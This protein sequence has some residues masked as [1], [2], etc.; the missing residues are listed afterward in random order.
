MK[1][2]FGILASLLAGCMFLLVSCEKERELPEDN[3]SP[4]FPTEVVTRNVAAG[5]A[6]ELPIEPNVKWTV[7]LSGEGSGN[8]FWIDDDGIKATQLSGNPGQHTIVVKF[9]EDKDFE[10]VVCDVNLKMGDQTRKI[11]TYTRLPQDRSCNVFTGVAGEFDFDKV[12]DSYVYGTS[13]V[14]ETALVTFPE[15]GEYRMPVKV[16]TNFDWKIALP[17]WLSAETVAQDGED[18]SKISEGES[19]TTEIML[20]VVLSDE[21]SNGAEAS[22]KIFDASTLEEQ[23]EMTVTMP[24]FNDRIE[25]VTINSLQFN[26]EACV[27]MPAGSFSEEPM[28]AIAYMF[29][30]EGAAMKAFAVSEGKCTGE[31]ADWVVITQAFDP[32]GGL[33]QSYPLEVSVSVNEGTA[34]Y[35]DLWAFPEALAEM[36]AKEL[37][38]SE[39]GSL[40]KEEY[41]MYYVGRIMQEGVIPPYIKPLSTEEQMLEAGTYYTLLEATSEENVLQWD[42]ETSPS[43]HRFIYTTRYSYEEADFEFSE[44]FEKC[45]LYK[46][47]DYPNGLFDT[48]VDP[49]DN[50]WLEF[51]LLDEGEKGYF[52][53]VKEP[54][55]PVQTAA[56]FYDKNDV[57]LGAVLIRYDVA[58]SGTDEFV[59]ELVEGEAVL[60]RL[61]EDNE[62]YQAFSD[63]YSVTDVYELSTS[64]E[65]VRLLASEVPA[66]FMIN[67]AEAPFPSYDP[68]PFTVELAEASVL[69]DNSGAEESLAAVIVFKAENGINR[70]AV[71]YRFEYVPEETPGEEPNPGEGGGENPD[72]EP[73][74][75]PGPE[76]EPEPDPIEV[77]PAVIFSLDS[78]TAELVKL[79]AES[80]LLVQVY[81]KFG[82]TQVYQVTTLSKMTTMVLSGYEVFG[83]MKLNADTLEETSGGLSSMEPMDN[84]IVMYSGGATSREE[85]LYVLLAEGDVPFAAVHYVFDP[86]ADIY[87]EPAFTFVY[88]DNVKGAEL[89]RYTGDDLQTYLEE[90]YG[91]EPHNVYELVYTVASPTR[92][93]V[94]VPSAPAFGTAWGNEAG[95]DDYWLQCSYTASTRQLKVTMKEAGLVDKFVFKHSDGSFSHILICTYKP[96]N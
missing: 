73:G 90:F 80:D 55:E 39:D 70:A 79:D 3:V 21:L 29:A 43:Y 67:K 76:P 47:S 89:H 82:M 26:K 37:Y 50:Y 72:P 53:I 35:A 36:E 63:G 65:A 31:V 44:P 77:D 2:I 66:A 6:V 16:V 20:S 69:I 96:A 10:T 87:I 52:N 64:D 42:F 81:E 14:N 59:L 11:A 75:D 68:C 88:P 92:P 17:E 61:T 22:L 45:V 74:P 19:G 91:V 48:E 34:R 85:A 38:D 15:S 95:T 25:N 33:I 71:Y 28:P 27:L 54:S 41:Q 40:V 12:E 86:L 62:I 60:T 57:I 9:S 56:V 84:N 8:R 23:Y 32:E 83:G 24:A 18:A 46:D 1:N 5:E 93:Q 7:L 51:V 78:G 13:T 30:T 49:E 58:S 4:V 94:K